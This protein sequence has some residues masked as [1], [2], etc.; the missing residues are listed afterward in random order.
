MN[1]Y[2]LSVIGAVL[3]CSLI[4]A[5]APEGKTSASIK[6]IA[7]LVCIL[8]I[9]APVLRFFKTGDLRVFID[10]NRQEFF[11]EEVIEADGEFI[12]YYCEMRIEQT[13]KALEME[14]LEKYGVETECTLSCRIEN[15]ICVEKICIKLPKDTDEEVKNAMRW[16]L[17][18]NYCSEVLIE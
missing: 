7:K 15:E 12:E 2:L 8:V 9:I 6:G 16:Y 11:S 3:L 17:K 5:I 4:T 14:L 18:E 1:G 10:K 13:E